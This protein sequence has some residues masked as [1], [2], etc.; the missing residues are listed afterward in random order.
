MLPYPALYAFFL[1]LGVLFESH[2]FFGGGFIPLEVCGSVSDKP[3]PY[4]T[5]QCSSLSV[6]AK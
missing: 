4:H 3:P 6:D 1:P 5:Q 2:A